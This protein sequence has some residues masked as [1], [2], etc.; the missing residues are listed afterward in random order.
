MKLPQ[1]PQLPLDKA[2]HVI[3]GVGLG[4]A[5]AVLFYV[6]GVMPALG[7]VTLAVASLADALATTVGGVAIAVATLM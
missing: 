3:Y 5:G 1:L 2:M 6:V 4:L 7:A